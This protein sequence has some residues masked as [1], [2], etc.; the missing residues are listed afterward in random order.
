MVPP[1]TSRGL[2][3]NS[4]A[5]AAGRG[6]L[7]SPTSRGLCADGAAE[8]GACSAAWDRPVCRSRLAL[9]TEVAGGVRPHYRRVCRSR[10]ARTG[11]GGC[12]RMRAVHGVIRAVTLWCHEC[13]A[14]RQEALRIA[15]STES[16]GDCRPAFPIRLQ[17][18]ASQHARRHECPFGEPGLQRGLGQ[19]RLQVEVGPLHRSCGSCAPTPPL[20]RVCSAAWDRPV[21]RSRLAPSTEAAGGV[22]LHYR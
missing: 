7:S 14:Q 6:W 1:A 20:R 13:T 15:P 3:A 17:G 4:A 18:E 22:R 21:C 11:G 9:S 2:C 19:A 8:D 5:E 16:I 12:G 10:L